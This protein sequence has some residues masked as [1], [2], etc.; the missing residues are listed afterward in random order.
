MSLRKRINIALLVSLIATLFIYSVFDIWISQRTLAST[1]EANASNTEK[2]IKVTLADA[3]WNFNVDSAQK[4]ASAEL[5]TNDLVGVSA[6][7]LEKQVLFDI[8]WDEDK[9]EMSVGQYQGKVLFTKETDIVYFDQDEAF[10]AGSVVLYFSGNS[11]DVAFSAAVKR[12]IFQILILSVIL[13]SV[14]GFLIHR[15]IISPLT[16][17]TERVNDIAQ[18]DGDLTRR[19]E[20]SSQGELHALT[21]GI[22]YFIDNVHK[23]VSDISKVSHTLDRSSDESNEDIKE[24]NDLVSDLNEKVSRIIHSMDGLSASSKD[25]ASQA[26]SSADV[27]QETTELAGKGLHDVRI[28]NE[29]TQQLADSVQSST[30]KTA[31]LD[32]HAQS[33]GAV[34]DVI[35]SIAEQTNL[36]ALN[37][38]IEAARAGEQGRGFA[39]VADEVRTLAQRTQKSTGEIEEIISQLQQQAKTTHNIMNSGMQQAADNVESAAKAGE[40]FSEIENAINRNV[41]SATTIAAAA[42]EQSQTLTSIESDIA[43]IRTANDRTLE[44]AR[45]SSSN[46]EAIVRLSQQ[47]AALVEKFKI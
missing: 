2:R 10:T 45:K 38:A 11:L 6:F 13:L 12:S 39:V 33:I 41:S 20:L 28:A 31:K 8:R 15:L 46:N 21:T 24:L 22:N 30:E 47:V 5:G 32:E 26:S 25:V 18:G 29:K 43:F 23:I 1:L 7:D 34:V 4:A 36:L 9:E 44:I 19:I 40:T 37:A 42:E 27:M 14:A 35:K 3:M 16:A 17:I